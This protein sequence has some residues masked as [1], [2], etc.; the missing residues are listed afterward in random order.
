MSVGNDID[1]ILAEMSVLAS[2]P[3]SRPLDAPFIKGGKASGSAPRD[4]GESL[5]EEWT[6]VFVRMAEAAKIALLRAQGHRAFRTRGRPSKEDR[7]KRILEFHEGQEARFVAYVEDVPE[8][9]V[10]K[11]RR[12]AERSPH[13]GRRRD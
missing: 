11:L 1:N 6:E 7:D 4:F 8:Q 5:H 10:R 9:S 2:A 13:D 3:A 12:D